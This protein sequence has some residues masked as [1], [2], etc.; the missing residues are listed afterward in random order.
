[1]GAAVRRHAIAIGLALSLTG[2][3]SGT[4]PGSSTSP[5][6]T[7]AEVQPAV[8]LG[9]PVEL[10]CIGCGHVATCRDQI[11]GP[12]RADAKVT[13]YVGGWTGIAIEVSPL[14]TGAWPEPSDVDP[15]QF[16]GVSWPS[17][18]LG[19]RLADGE[20]AVVDGAGRLV[21]TT[22]KDYQFRGEWVLAGSTGGPIF[23]RSF[24]EGFSVCGDHR[25]VIPG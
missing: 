25:S 6:S 3:H 23:P 7:A 2:C 1:M 4:S 15:L 17:D 22:G 12:L 13:T 24:I 14:D 21:G 16:V 10:G 5:A 18:Y 11:A 9:T 19:S 20:I 8:V